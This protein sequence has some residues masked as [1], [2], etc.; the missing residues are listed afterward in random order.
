[1][2]H[3]IKKTFNLFGLEINRLQPSSDPILQTVKAMNVIN[4]NIVLDVGANMGQFAMDIRKK[5]YKG[6]I[7]SFEPL[8]NAWKQLNYNASKDIN[9]KVHERAA[10]GNRNGFIDINISKNSVSSSILPMLE[11]HLKAADS[12]VYIG[13]ES[14]P[15]ITLDSVIKEYLPVNSSCF[16]K[17]DTQ[18]FEWQV[19]HGAKDSLKIVNGII[20]EVSLVPLYEGQVLYKDIIN[21]LENEGFVL[22]SLIKG[23]MDTKSGRSLQMDA[24]FLKKDKV[25]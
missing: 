23:F 12:S 14:T 11:S 8:K 4:T 24:I 25:K 18:G 10:V 5:G 22:W 2:K 13:Y 19:F 6:K 20:C 16:L 17:I 9:W 21:R 7:V 15:M 1:M 3:L